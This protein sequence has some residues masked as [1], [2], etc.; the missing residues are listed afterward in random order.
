MRAPAVPGLRVE[1]VCRCWSAR[2]SSLQRSH[3]K[4][5]AASP[6]DPAL[7]GARR[8]CVVLHPHPARHGNEAAA[9]QHEVSQ[10]RR[11]RGRARG[12]P[13]CREA[14]CTAL[15]GSGLQGPVSSKAKHGVGR[16]S[17]PPR[18]FAPCTWRRAAGCKPR[19]CGGP[20]R[21]KFPSTGPEC[22]RQ[23]QQ[24][25][26][27]T[28]ERQRPSAKQPRE[29][30]SQ[31]RPKLAQAASPRTCRH[32]LMLQA[33]LLTISTA[34]GRTRPRWRRQSQ[35][36]MRCAKAWLMPVGATGVSPRRD[37]GRVLGACGRQTLP[38]KPQEPSGGGIGPRVP[39][40]TTAAKMPLLGNLGQPTASQLGSGPSAHPV[41]AVM[42][43]RT[44]G[45]G[46]QRDRSGFVQAGLERELCWACVLEQRPQASVLC[47]RCR[48]FRQQ[49]MF[50][51]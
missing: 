32:R 25:P 29:G 44:T 36:W 50:G 49:G 34:Q 42:R 21:V 31:R 33:R 11:H 16:A 10:V 38:A 26:R 23:R 8:R 43:L 9:S 5:G 40:C 22:T 48:R 39:R 3:C 45:A 20:S 14:A 6:R 30:S 27:P 19:S 4:L 1:R 2:V 24:R 13:P 18:A 17:S 28:S 41:R 35:S 51:T 47:Q 7:S 37:G 46:S 15:L 12:R